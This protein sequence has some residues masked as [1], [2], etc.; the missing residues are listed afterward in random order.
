MTQPT[1]HQP[2]NSSNVTTLP[3]PDETQPVSP[4]HEQLTQQTPAASIVEPERKLILTLEGKILREFSIGDQNLSIGRKHGNDIQLN[5]L[6]LSGRHALVSSIPDYV[7]IEDLGSTNGT[8]VNGNHVKKI[9]LEHGDIIQVG[10]HQLTYMCEPE[11]RY[12]P[13]MFVKAELDDTQFIYDGEINQALVTGLALGGLRTVDGHIPKP[14]MELRKTY[15]TIGFQ[16]KRMALIT[17]GSEGYSITSVI[18]TRS[19]RAS[20]IPRI[21]GEELGTEQFLLS[22]GDIIN[23]AGFEIQFYYLS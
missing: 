22:E 5:D 11:T 16:G 15:N 20:D 10:H 2:A 18:G 4:E 17:R 1:Q 9:A 12:E 19:R 8:L 7:F 14:V 13:T 3:K 21:N 6:T 23:I